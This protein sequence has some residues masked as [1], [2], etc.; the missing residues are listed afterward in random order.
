MDPDKDHFSRFLQ[1]GGG[2]A[3]AEERVPFLIA[4]CTFALILSL[5]L[6]RRPA[7]RPPLVPGETRPNAPLGR[8]RGCS[9]RG[10]IVDRHRHSRHAGRRA[11]ARGGR[12]RCGR[13]G[14]GCGGS[15]PP[16]GPASHPGG[17]LLFAPEP[18]ARYVPPRPPDGG[19]RRPRRRRQRPPRPA[20]GVPRRRY[21]ELPQGAGPRGPARPP[22][23]VALSTDGRLVG[24]AAG[25]LPPPAQLSGAH[26]GRPGR[27]GAPDRGGGPYAPPGGGPGP[28]AQGGATPSATA[29]D[30]SPAST[31][32][33]PPR[34][35]ADPVYV[36]VTD[37]PPGAVAPLEVL[38]ALAANAMARPA[39][40]AFPD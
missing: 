15:C 17:V 3:G 25:R 6:P 37:P 4:R 18:L 5:L 36:A 28:P 30:A 9:T 16:P 13:G 39:V 23:G 10:N 34:P 21:R 22:V 11:P 12:R 8:G 35:P 7:P 14:G 38:A 26:P 1:G 2:A 24:P 27:P 32:P 40:A 33:A 31:A 29:E 19:R 20:A